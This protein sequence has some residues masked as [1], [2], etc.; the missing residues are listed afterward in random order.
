MSL[1]NRLGRYALIA[2]GL[3][4]LYL[5]VVVL[6]PHAG[7]FEP[8][9]AF[10]TLAIGWGMYLAG[11]VALLAVI[12]IVAAVVK[13]P[14]IGWKSGLLALLVPAGFVLALGGLQDTASSVPLLHDISTDTAN[15]PQFTDVTLAA[16]ED[17]NAKNPIRGFDFK[18]AETEPWSETGAFDDR[19]DLTAAQLIADGY[20]DVQPLVLSGNTSAA[21]IAEAMRSI[22]LDEVRITGNT[23]EGVATTLPFAFKDDVVARL[24]PSETGGTRVDFRSTSRVGL[25]D[26]GYNAARIME[27]REAVE[28]QAGG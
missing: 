8:L 21:D 28:A 11:A 24:T 25:S 3:L 23:V 17:W 12:G 13:A 4:L 6:G 14:R 19:P 27:L 18:L 15:P 5:L 10:S 1:R 26:L 20:P 16:R 7:L 2:A 9:Y 22:G